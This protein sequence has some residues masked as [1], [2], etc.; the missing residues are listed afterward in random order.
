MTPSAEPCTST[1][2][3]CEVCGWK[4]FEPEFVMSC[5]KA[6]FSTG[7]LRRTYCLGGP[8]Q[9]SRSCVAP[10]KLQ[11]SKNCSSES[12]RVGTRDWGL[13]GTLY[14]EA[15]DNVFPWHVRSCN[16]L[17]CSCLMNRR[18]PWMLRRSE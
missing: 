8:L 16:I 2:L 15:S 12:P 1:E 10:S 5:R 9:R 6:S 17:P 18:R 14:R 3:T 11:A 4:V 13:E 7:R